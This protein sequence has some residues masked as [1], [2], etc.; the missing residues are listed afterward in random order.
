[1]DRWFLIAATALAAMAGV[2]GL[3]IL[4]HG[5]KSHWTVWWMI[6]ALIFVLYTLYKREKLVRRAG[7]TTETSV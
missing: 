1:V 2:R 7:L 5:N 4:R 3:L 6:A